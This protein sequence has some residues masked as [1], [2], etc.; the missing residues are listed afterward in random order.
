M[1]GNNETSIVITAIDNTEAALNSVKGNVGAVTG[2]FERLGGVVSGFAALAG[3]TAF[4]G[5]IKGSIDSAAGLNDMAQKTGATVESLSALRG[6]AKLADVEMET[7]AGGLQKL[8]KN[9]MEAAS[10]SGD[11]KKVFDALGISVRDSSGNLKSSDAVMMEFSKS[12]QMVSSG[13]ERAAAAQV[14]FGKSGAQLMPLL[15]DL[16]LT[17]ELQAKITTEQAAAADNFGDTLIK[18]QAVHKSWV[19]TVAMEVLPAANAFVETMLEMAVSSNGMKQTA[20]DLAADGSIQAWSKSAAMGIARVIDVVQVAAGTFTQFQQS[21]AVVMK[22]VETVAKVAALGI[23]A[24]FTAEGQ[25]AIKQAL[26][27][28]SEFVKAANEDLQKWWNPELFSDKLAKK[29]DEAGTAAKTAAGGTRSL[30]DALKNVKD[31]SDKLA[32]APAALRLDQMALITKQASAELDA[33]AKSQEEWLKHVDALVGPLEKQADELER[34]VEFYGMTDS[35]IQQTIIA[36][37]EEQLEIL[38]GQTGMESLI[39]TLEREVEAR[40][41]IASAASQKEYLDANKKASEDAARQWENFS[42][43]IERSLTDSLYRAFESGQ[44]FG[45]AFANSLKNTFKSMVL[46]VAVQAVV[47][48]GGS[49]VNAGINAVLGT[50]GSNGG[51]G[52]NYLGMANNASSLYNAYNGAYSSGNL[53]GTAGSAYGNLFGG[54]AYA[55]NSAV[56]SNSFSNAMSGNTAQAATDYQVYTNAYEQTGNAAYLDAANASSEGAGAGSS[57]GQYASYAAYAYALY[58]LSQGDYKTAGGAAGA[59][60]GAQYGSSVYPGIGTVIGAV[61]GYIAGSALG[62]SLMGGGPKSELY[63]GDRSTGWGL[64]QTAPTNR[65]MDLIAAGVTTEFNNILKEFGASVQQIKVGLGADADPMGD[66]SSRTGYSVTAGGKTTFYEGDVGKLDAAT[67]QANA[68]RALLSALESVDISEPVNAYLDSLG[69]IGK[70]TADQATQALTTIQ[71]YHDVNAAMEK[72]NFGANSLT[73]SLIGAFGG[74]NNLQSALSSYYSNYYTAEEQRAN[75]ITQITSALDAAGATF[76]EAQLGSMSRADFRAWVE[77]IDKTTD[78]GKAMF[79]AAL[80]VSSAFA[81]VTKSMD[82][83]TSA[84]QTAA[85]VQQEA[86]SSLQS[87]WSAMNSTASTLGNAGQTGGLE[88]MLA[89]LQSGYDYITNLGD[90]AS[91][92]EKIG[93]LQDTLTQKQADAIQVGIDSAQKQL[94]NAKAMLDVAKSIQQYVDSLKVSALSALAPEQK[95]AEAAGQYTIALA[96]AKAGDKEAAGKLQGFSDSYLGQARDYYGANAQYATIFGSVTDGLSQ[97]SDAMIEKNDPLV[98][99]LEH[100]ISLAQQSLSVGS[101]QLDLTQQLY[102]QAAQ[103]FQA[104]LAQISQQIVAT[105]SVKSAI[106]ALPPELAGILSASVA[107]NSRSSLEGYASA[108]HLTVTSGAMDSLVKSVATGASSISS[109]QMAMQVESLYETMAGRTADSAGLAYWTDRATS[110]GGVSSITDAFRAGL[111]ASGE[112]PKFSVGTN[113]IPHDMLAVLHEGEAVVPKVYNPAAGGHLTSTPSIDPQ[114]TNLLRDLVLEVGRLRD[115]HG[116]AESDKATRD[117]QVDRRLANIE[118]AGTLA[119]AR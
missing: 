42:R 18:L 60:A 55:G 115:Q 67:L 97:F 95:L 90:K 86:L 69:E 14:V 94:D 105:D 49:L 79:A 77:G 75:T 73:S 108:N 53:F 48:T 98:D 24:G 72:L 106:A 7:V 112:I 36:R 1:A 44:S 46:K 56:Y 31:N 110:A 10:G 100:Q 57:M 27:E 29:F 23:G 76:S 47:S 20:K 26:N 109:A 2:Q 111:I 93:S 39:E 80:Q 38:R 83:V 22:D 91:V 70:L 84:A 81:S 107:A 103:Q 82:D 17:G 87:A 4:A 15:N 50:S 9:M 45:E 35:A 85:A 41:R 21:M 116:R 16:A 30:A 63:G 19:T 34:Q 58:S 88:S 74:I 118:S 65:G 99:R 68:N 102:T 62:S 119:R 101:R 92:L 6:A 104:S 78:A 89:S 11:T 5:I 3:V 25:A 114:V 64:A 61:V 37:K 33:I 12:L 43:D 13:S 66:A 59:A 117:A 96:A 113:Y 71:T 8:S 32:A 28:R 40:K 54:S 51:A 52:N